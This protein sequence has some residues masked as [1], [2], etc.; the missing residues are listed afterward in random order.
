M[1]CGHPFIVATNRES[2]NQRV[3][4]RT[5]FGDRRIEEGTLVNFVLCTSMLF[6]NCKGNKKKG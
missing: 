4:A 1:A 6:E 3:D 2:C 5:H